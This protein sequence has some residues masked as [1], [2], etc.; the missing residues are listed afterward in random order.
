MKVTCY[1]G[2]V[3]PSVLY[4][5]LVRRG[6]PEDEAALAVDAAVEEECR[7]LRE[8]QHSAEQLV[9]EVA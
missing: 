1:M 2:R 6:R 8:L 3:K 4:A 9:R 5:D 7:R